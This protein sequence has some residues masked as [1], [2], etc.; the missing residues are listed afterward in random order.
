V[1]GTV[2][3][4]TPKKDQATLLRAVAALADD[5]APTLVLVGLGPLEGELRD[6]AARLGIDRRGLF[7]GARG[8]VFEL[9]PG[10][11]ALVL[12]SRL[13]GLPSARPEAMATGV[14]P[15]RARGG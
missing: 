9:L 5:P 2:G 3:N 12:S 14:A 6:L 13:E 8:D 11:D 4:F 7:A 1:V 10:L 15:A